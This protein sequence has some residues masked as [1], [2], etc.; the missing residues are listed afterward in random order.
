MTK[1]LIAEM[2]IAN[3]DYADHEAI[4]DARYPK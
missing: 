3:L 1:A 4:E 2:I